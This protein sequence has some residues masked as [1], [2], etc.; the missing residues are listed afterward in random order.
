MKKC[1]TVSLIFTLVISLAVPQGAVFATDEIINEEVVGSVPIEESVEPTIDSSND[2]IKENDIS[3]S[4]AVAPSPAVNEIQKPTEQSIIVNDNPT[5]S[6]ESQNSTPIIRGVVIAQIQVGA[7]GDAKDEYISLYNN[8][9]KEVDITGWCVKNKKAS[10]SDMPCFSKPDIDFVIK[11]YS[12]IA[13]SSNEIQGSQIMTLPFNTTCGQSSSG[14]IVATNEVIS[15]VNKNGEVIDKIEWQKT[16][17]NKYAIERPWDVTKPRVLKS[18]AT[19]WLWKTGLENYNG[20]AELI[21]C[22]DGALVE[23]TNNCPKAPIYCSNMPGVLFSSL[24]AGS[25]IDNNGNCYENK[26]TNLPGFHREP[27]D[28]FVANDNKTCTLDLLPIEITELLP[29]PKGNDKGNEFIE[30]YNPNSEDVDLVWWILY[31]NQ[32][33]TKFYSFPPDMKIKAGEYKVIDQNDVAFTL[34]NDSGSVRLRSIDNQFIVDVPDWGKSKEGKS[35]SLLNGVWQYTDPSPGEE[36]RLSVLEPDEISGLA[37][38]GEGRERNP[39]TGR[40][41]NITMPKEYAPCKD[42]QYRSE[43]TNRCRNIALA[44]D[45]LKPCKEGQYRSEETNRCRNIASAASTKKPCNDDQFRNPETGRCKKIAS[46]E[47]VADCGEGR[48]R[49]PK[50][51]RCR[52]IVATSAPEVGFSPEQVKQTAGAMWGWWVFGGVSIVALGYAGWQWRWEIRQAATKFRAIFTRS[53]K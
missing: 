35:W 21:E 45:T 53:G 33:Y 41:R 37:D 49:N 47:E 40:C 48:E 43:E 28:G 10:S 32:E 7:T 12:F 14:C 29:N 9:D 26:C 8:S 4:S 39:A 27:P 22:S 42:G 17:D 16:S 38:C 34:K 52:N 51:N 15:L 36:N 13:L 23:N 50:T 31:L 5:V 25:E 19:D 3:I 20:I 44:G 2:E 18:G 6:T 24:P 11:P 1:F 30:L 46:S